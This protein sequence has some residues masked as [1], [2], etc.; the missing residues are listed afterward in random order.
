M[1]SM[2]N[3]WGFSVSVHP[4]LQVL[5]SAK[6]EFSFFHHSM[7]SVGTAEFTLNSCSVSSISEQV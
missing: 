4:R 6:L 3:G 2:W 5:P 1:N 7:N